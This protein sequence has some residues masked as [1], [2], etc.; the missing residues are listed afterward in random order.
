MTARPNFLVIMS[1]QHSPHFLGCAGERL[2]R[3]PHL[4]AL[5]ERGVAFDANYCAAPLCVPSRMTFLTGRHA[6]AT[7]LPLDCAAVIVL[8]RVHVWHGLPVGVQSSSVTL[9]PVR[10]LPSRHLMR[11]S[12]SRRTV[13]NTR[14]GV[15]CNSLCR[16][17]AVWV[18]CLRL[19]R[20]LRSL[21]SADN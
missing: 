3:T 15:A 20:F 8:S 5:A 7:D 4:D 14:S 21:R 6:A 16:L 10:T 2:V 17:S 1:D 9:L 18:G 19:L 13:S 12:E 11:I